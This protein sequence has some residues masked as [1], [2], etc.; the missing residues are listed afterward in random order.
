MD[1]RRRR[2]EGCAA[3]VKG[4]AVFAFRSGSEEERGSERE[5]E[6]QP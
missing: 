2:V 5:G 1:G 3:V 6:E 4:A